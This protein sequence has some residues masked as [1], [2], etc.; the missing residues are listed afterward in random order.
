MR[1]AFKSLLGAIVGTVLA[2]GLAGCAVNPATGR[3]TFTAFMS[4]ADEIRIGREEHPKILDEFGGQYHDPAIR[5]YL[6]QIGGEL[7]RVAEEPNVPFTFT[8]L[9][10]DIV[11]AFALPGGYVYVT[12]GLMALAN[13]EAELAGVIAHEIGHIAARH[14]AERYSTALAARIGLDALGAL[15]GDRL[16]G[17]GAALGATLALSSLSR[18]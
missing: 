15:T 10:S 17:Q 9:N 7:R 5:R 4:A 11:N 2:L 12:A 14:T 13:N 16:L 6:S 3:P 1:R 18:E 8:V